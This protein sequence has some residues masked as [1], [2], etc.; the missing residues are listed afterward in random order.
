MVTHFETGKNGLRRVWAILEVRRLLVTYQGPANQVSAPKGGRSVA[1]HTPKWQ[2]GTIL[3]SVQKSL[4][5]GDSDECFKDQ[6]RQSPVEECLRGSVAA[7]DLLIL[8]NIDSTAVL[9]F[10]TGEIRLESLTS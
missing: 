8:R 10:R 9:P 4:A 3:C 1:E 5:C 7:P 2:T 6:A